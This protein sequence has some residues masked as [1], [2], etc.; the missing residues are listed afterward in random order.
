[1]KS[2]FKK[3]QKETDALTKEARKETLKYILGAFSF[4]VGLAWRDATQALVEYIYPE[5]SGS[6][7]FLFAYAIVF[8]II[9]VVLGRYSTRLFL[10]EE[11]EKEQESK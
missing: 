7:I 8:T 4:I 3:A 1:M 2:P 6:I 5:G 9:V 10:D 11:Q